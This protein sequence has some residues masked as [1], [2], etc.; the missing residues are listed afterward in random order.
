MTVGSTC[1]PCQC[2]DNINTRDPYSCDTQTGDCL[3]CL[4]NTT[5]PSCDRCLD[6]FY[7]DAVEAKD[8]MGKGMVSCTLVTLYEYVYDLYYS[9]SI[10]GIMEL[11]FFCK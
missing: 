4:Y 7:G 10:T 2:N 11:C 9:F 6:W 1:E 8:C 3:K 5:G